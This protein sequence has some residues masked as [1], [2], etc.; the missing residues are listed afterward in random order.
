MN[1]KDFIANLMGAIPISMMV[2]KLES[3]NTDGFG[4]ITNPVK[5]SLKQRKSWKGRIEKEVKDLFFSVQVPVNVIATYLEIEGRF[6][7]TISRKAYL[8][9]RTWAS[10]W[11]EGQNPYEA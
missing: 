3:D 11:Y 10:M 4:W 6:H 2:P 7:V 9:D 5:L 1:R 8:Q